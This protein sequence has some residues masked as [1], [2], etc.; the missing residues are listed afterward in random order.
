MPTFLLRME[1]VNFDASLYDTNDLSTIRGSSLALLRAGGVALAALQCAP[2]ATNVET[3]FTGASQAAFTFDTADDV[4]AEP[5][6]AHVRSVLTSSKAAGAAGGP[7]AELRDAVAQLSFVVDVVPASTAGGADALEVAMARNRTRQ[8]REWTLPLPVFDPGAQ[9]PDPFDS[10]RPAT[11]SERRVPPGKFLLPVAPPRGKSDGERM[12][13]PSVVARRA[14]GRT[15]RQEFYKAET[16]RGIGKGLAYTDEF[17]AIVAN[18][19][20]KVPLSLRSK[21]AVLYAD[22]NGFGKIRA[23]MTAEHGNATDAFRDFSGQLVAL[24]RGLL[25]GLCDWYG[26]GIKASEAG[27]DTFAVRQDKSSDSY[28]LRLETLL[29]GGDELMFVIPAWLALAALQ[30]FFAATRGWQIKGPKGN[31][32]LTHAAGLVICHHKTPIRQAKRIAEELALACKAAAGGR[33]AAS[34]AIFESLSPSET[35]LA[36]AR[37]GLYGGRSKDELEAIDKMLV[38]PGD[39][40]NKVGDVIAALKSEG[41]E[42][43]L[44]RSKLYDALRAARGKG[45]LM[46]NDAQAAIDELLQDY[47]TRVRGLETF[48][49]SR[50]VLPQVDGAN[51]TLPVTLGLIAELWDYVAPFP[52]NRLPQFGARKAA[53]A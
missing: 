37:A 3:V 40:F 32:D 51:R 11:A 9:A 47:A 13:A 25:Q 43:P 16:G 42:A 17:E 33:N 5:V 8:Y 49:A 4:V 26:A 48:D 23:A 31:H 50:L 38:I 46:T 36:E 30:G 20:D 1:G 15:Q 27:L 39:G 44:P 34:I 10:T 14:Y 28:D 19:P 24:R 53:T 21:M 18:P 45:G 52:D 2:G 7:E 22:G 6:A 29:W 41:D 12:Y 35:A